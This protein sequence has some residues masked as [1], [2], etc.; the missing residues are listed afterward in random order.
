MAEQERGQHADTHAKGGAGRQLAG[1][2]QQ[3]RRCMQHPAALTLQ[4][5][6]DMLVANT[7]L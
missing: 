4:M 6:N 2:L 3:P 7:S 1:R 5:T